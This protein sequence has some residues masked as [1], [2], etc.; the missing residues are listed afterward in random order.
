MWFECW[1]WSK[2]CISLPS[3]DGD[4]LDIEFSHMAKILI[5]T[6][7]TDVQW[8]FLGGAHTDVLGA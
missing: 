6:L 8:S 3:K 5:E 1:A 2:G 4:G 7:D